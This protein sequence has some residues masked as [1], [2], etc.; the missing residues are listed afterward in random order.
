MYQM[1]R[2]A[3]ASDMLVPVKRTRVTS[4]E[5]SSDRKRAKDAAAASSTDATADVDANA[6]K[7]GKRAIVP[8]SA[9]A[10]PSRDESGV[11]DLL[12]DMGSVD[13]D[14]QYADQ[15]HAL[16]EFLKLHPMLSLFVPHSN[17]TFAALGST[18]SRVRR[19]STSHTT[20]QLMSD[21]IGSTSMPTRTLELVPKSY[22]DAYLRPPDTSNG[23]RACCLAE[24]CICVW[25]ARWR[26]G[27]DTDMAF[28]GAEFLLPSERDAFQK[29]RTLPVTHGKCL[30]CSRYMHTYVYRLARTDPTF[31]ASDAVP[32]QAYGNVLGSCVGETLPTHSS[33]V[34][35]GDGYR[36]ESM[37]FVDESWTES[38]AARTAMGTFLWRPCVKFYALHY[39]YVHAEN[40]KPRLVQMGV[41]TDEDAERRFA[42]RFREPV[43]A[44]ARS[45]SATRDASNGRPSSLTLSP[46]RP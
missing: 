30:V 8:A 21:L 1:A 10:G 44:A 32:L 34:A 25:M 24:R 9:P 7:P 38:P 4:S 5:S 20:L 40:G 33:V 31:R 19:E 27:P 13:A 23:E 26:Y 15:E 37:L 14:E 41:G 18:G 16:N 46:S 22:D 36:S 28:V 29:S 2:K 11:P 45:R 3:S 35:D 6:G 42:Q 43:L 39:R 12:Q 17:P